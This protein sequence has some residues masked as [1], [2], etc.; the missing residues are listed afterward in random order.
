MAEPYRGRSIAEGLAEAEALVTSQPIS[1]FG[2]V[3]PESG[4]VTEI[5][6][7]LFGVSVAGK[8]LVM[9]PAKGS[10]AST[11]IIARSSE[12]KV[13]PA[14]IVIQKADIIL[15]AGVIIARV[16][17][18][19]NFDFDPVVKFKTGQILRV[20]GSEGTVEVKSGEN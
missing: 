20:N 1:F 5:G 9:P 4:R 7:E 11:W 16:P 18:V 8:V 17:T 19:D 10:T 12:N 13:A 15:I 2:S 14:A 6:H 3:D